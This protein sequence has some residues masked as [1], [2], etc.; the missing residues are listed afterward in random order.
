[1]STTPTT[2]SNLT[3]RYIEPSTGWVPLRLAEIW[4]YRELLYFLVWRTVKIRYKHTML[5]LGWALVQPLVT[6]VVFT[7]VFHKVAAV[8]SEGMPYPLFVLAALVP[9]QL[10]AFALTESSNSLIANQNLITKVYFPRLIIP[11]ASILV[12]LIDFAVA[13]VVV[14]GLMVYYRITPTAALATLPLWTGLAVLTACAIGVWLSALIVRFRDIRYTLPFAT[15]VLLI[16]TPVAYGLSSIDP[17]L[18]WLYALNPMTGVVTGF[19]WALLGVAPMSA[20][21]IISSLLL[22]AVLC[23]TGVFYFH[24]MERTVADRV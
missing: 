17:A 2:A 9:W 23:V 10:F 14:I 11:L 18:R 21:E 7:V 8:S 4:E 20:L 16:A 1:M 19:R 24:R 5:G 15:Q 13:F 3:V 12:A 6:T 22:V